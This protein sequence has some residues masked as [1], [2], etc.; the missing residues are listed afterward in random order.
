M[1]LELYQEGIKAKGNWLEASALVSAARR[2]ACQILRRAR[3]KAKL[4]KLSAQER[5]YNAGMANNLA[6]LSTSLGES[7]EKLNADRIRAI[8]FLEREVLQLISGLCT[9]VLNESFHFNSE[10]IGWRIKNVL[11]E[12]PISTCTLSINSKGHSLLQSCEELKDLNCSFTVDDHLADGVL[13]VRNEMGSL[14]FDWR[15]D[16]ECML[17][18]LQP[19]ITKELCRVN[20]EI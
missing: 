4:A 6:I 11:T 2:K 7:N 18:T 5:G 1:A 9:A 13:A 10:A 12:L 15:L 8:K 17:Q 3:K 20:G 19:S 14:L 16:L